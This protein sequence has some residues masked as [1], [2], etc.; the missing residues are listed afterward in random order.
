M[1]YWDASALAPLCVNEPT[2]ERLR[3][4]AASTEI[5][6][7]YGSLVEVTSAIERRHRERAMAAAVYTVAKENL[8]ALANSWVEVSPSL[9]LRDR[10]L[11]LLAVHSLRASDAFQLAAALVVVSDR[12]HQHYFVCQDQRLLGAARREGFEVVSAR[13]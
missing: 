7:W 1:H 10:A 6:T 12:P 5:V 3:K 11:R 8:R 13:L 2:S 9:V 4:L